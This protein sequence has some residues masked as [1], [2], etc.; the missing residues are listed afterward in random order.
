MENKC[1]FCKKTFKSKSNLKTHITTAKYC[2][3]QRPNNDVTTSLK[4]IFK[5]EGCKSELSSRQILDNHKPKC[6]QLILKRTEEEHSKQIIVLQN[7]IAEKDKQIQDLQNKLENIALKAISR[8]T[9]IVNTNTNTDNRV[10]QVVNNL[11][12]I[13]DEHLKEQ[14]RFLTLEH[15]L[16][17]AVGYASF[18]CEHALKDRVAC[19]DISRKKIKYKNAD[20]QIISDP[21][22]RILTKKFFSAIDDKNKEL[23]EQY[24][25]QLVDKM[26]SKYHEC[27]DD[28]KDE[29][30]LKLEKYIDEINKNMDSIINIYG[31]AIDISQGK[32]PE[33]FHQFVREVCSKTV[34]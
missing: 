28:M 17:G 14:S 9:S 26:L 34:T 33:M 3:S 13:T 25:K 21:E 1:E 4:V 22:M 11:I 27:G 10:Q 5:C 6:T 8:P 31:Q 16:K 7:I 12:P 23:T 2:I 32:H 18:A 19:T 20:G 29:D 24:K 15:I 30:T